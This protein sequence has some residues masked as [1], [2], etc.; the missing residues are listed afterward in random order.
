MAGGV[1][2][3]AGGRSSRRR[4]RIGTKVLISGGGKCNVAHAGPIEEVL[5]G[6]PPERGAVHPA[7][8]ATA[9]KNDAIVSMMTDRG[10]R[11]YT[12]DDGRVFPVD[13]TAKDVVEI[14]RGYLDEAGVEV[15]LETPVA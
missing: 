4:T 14:L 11:V 1:A 2:G 3:G 13:Q 5:Q 10:L 9:C 12:R 15:R 8:P 7:L 6:V